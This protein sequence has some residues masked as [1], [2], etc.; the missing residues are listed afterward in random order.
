[1]MTFQFDNFLFA[2]IV[3]YLRVQGAAFAWGPS[4]KADPESKRNFLFKM[5]KMGLTLIQKFLS[6]KRK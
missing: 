1:M 6:E 5:S 2:S 4:W 3:L